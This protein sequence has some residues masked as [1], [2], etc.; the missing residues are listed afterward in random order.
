MEVLLAQSFLGPGLCGPRNDRAETAGAARLAGDLLSL[1]AEAVGAPGSADCYDMAA[2][3]L[4][5]GIDEPFDFCGSRQGARLLEEH[6]INT[7]QG[8][9]EDT[10]NLGQKP[11][12]C[13]HGIFP[14]VHDLSTN[15]SG[16]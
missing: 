13:V 2:A 1:F 11:P 3:Y 4:E 7:M 9:D 15:H 12:Y 5:Y 10:G 6:P 16:G 14:T 8:K